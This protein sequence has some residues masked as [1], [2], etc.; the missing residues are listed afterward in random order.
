M[1]VGLLFVQITANLKI[2]NKIL[3]ALSRVYRPGGYSSE[4]LDQV[5][6]SQ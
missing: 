5:F 6:L 2:I 3:G 1:G 4:V